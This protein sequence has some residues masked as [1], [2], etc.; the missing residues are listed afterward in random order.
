MQRKLKETEN[1]VHKEGKIIKVTLLYRNMLYS[2]H[3]YLS[4]YILKLTPHWNC[5]YKVKAYVRCLMVN[6]ILDKTLAASCLFS[7]VFQIKDWAKHA[8]VRDKSL[9]D[10]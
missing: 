2:K 8:A 3:T 5:L 9:P 7:K 1:L 6:Y 10:H 4:I